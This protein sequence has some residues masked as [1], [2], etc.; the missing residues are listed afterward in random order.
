MDA[1]IHKLLELRSGISKTDRPWK[2]QEFVVKTKDS[3]LCLTA[4][5]D[6]VD[7]LKGAKEGD[8]VDVEFY[9]GAREY[10][11]KWYTSCTVTAL[12][13]PNRFEDTKDDFQPPPEEKEEQSD[14]P[15]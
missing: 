11:E 15:F 8:D 9:V 2:A 7:L 1:K 13:F 14:L 6:V 10:R 12:K 4:L 3:F 5:N